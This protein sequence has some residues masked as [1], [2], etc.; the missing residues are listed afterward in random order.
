M[1]LHVKGI[2]SGLKPY[3]EKIKARLPGDSTIQI[4]NVDDS[5]TDMSD[6]DNDASSSDDDF[7]GMDDFSTDVQPMPDTKDL[8]ENGKKKQLKKRRD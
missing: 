3:M 8:E 7:G 4:T 5:S 1:D 6:T 2:Y